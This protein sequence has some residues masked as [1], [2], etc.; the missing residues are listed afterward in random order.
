MNDTF[1]KNNVAGSSIEAPGGANQ[2]A[3]GATTPSL[4]ICYLLSTHD[5]IRSRCISCI[6]INQGLTA[7][8]PWHLEGSFRWLGSEHS[9]RSLPRDC[10]AAN[11]GYCVDPAIRLSSKLTAEFIRTSISASSTHWLPRWPRYPLLV[12]AASFR[13]RQIWPKALQCTGGCESASMSLLQASI[14]VQAADLGRSSKSH[15]SN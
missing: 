10:I 4:V 8:L 2:A 12:L 15:K 1:S 7:P 14:D 13:G 11:A 3:W 9:G 5:H 6:S